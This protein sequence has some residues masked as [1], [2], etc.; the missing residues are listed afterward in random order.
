MNERPASQQPDAEE[1][2]GDA[3]CW[4]H[5]L[6]EDCGVVVTANDGHRPGCSLLLGSERLPETQPKPP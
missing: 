6:C 3:A 5:L 1:P 2:G 4:V